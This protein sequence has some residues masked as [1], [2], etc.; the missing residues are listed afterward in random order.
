MVGCG[1]YGGAEDDNARAAAAEDAKFME[2]IRRDM[3]AAT[4]T[5]REYF[6]GLAMQG[7]VASCSNV[8][9]WPCPHMIAGRAV[10]HADALIEAL[11]KETSD[12][13]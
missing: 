4:L 13:A 9:E 1:G 11:N 10:G 7:L 6:A 12:E 3:P 5:K 2:N 8:S